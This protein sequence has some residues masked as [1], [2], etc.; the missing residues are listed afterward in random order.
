M[1]EIL[2]SSTSLSKPE[3]S[4]LTQ[5][6]SPLFFSSS[7]PSA[8]IEPPLAEDTHDAGGIAGANRPSRR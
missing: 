5:G 7:F 4:E 6:R 3:A 8:T 2:I 1:F